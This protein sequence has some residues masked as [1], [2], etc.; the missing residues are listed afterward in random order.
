M[1]DTELWKSRIRSAAK[2]AKRVAIVA[3]QQADALM[4][5]AR[6][7]VETAARRRKAQRRL[8]QASRVLKTA[9]RA[10]VAAGAVAAV[11]AIAREVN[12]RRKRD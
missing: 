12:G 6:Q 11:A 9:G 8:Q 4:K 5:V 10:A 7:K 2:E 1:V 3:G